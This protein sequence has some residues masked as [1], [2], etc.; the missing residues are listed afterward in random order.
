MSVKERNIVVPKPARIIGD[1]KARF[2]SKEVN[3]ELS[4]CW[5]WTGLRNDLGY[6]R[7][8]TTDEHGNHR[9]VK[10]HTLSFDWEY[11]P[12]P[13]GFERDHL[14]RNP[15]CVRPDHLEA[16]THAENMR[17]SRGKRQ[18]TKTRCANG[19]I[20]DSYT[21][22]R[23]SGVTQRVCRECRKVGQRNRRA[24]KRAEVSA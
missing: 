15:P 2:W 16:V 6:G 14:C 13:P 7:L 20:H 1:L 24:R 5:L 22:K 21:W 12:P 8:M 11:G 17:R 3:G 9:G 4:E 19:H 23:T 10:A 18:F